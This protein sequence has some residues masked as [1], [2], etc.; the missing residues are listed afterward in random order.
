MN[1]FFIFN[2]QLKSGKIKRKIKYKNEISNV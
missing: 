2:D 1:S